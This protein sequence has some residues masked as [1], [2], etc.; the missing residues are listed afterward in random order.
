M[1]KTMSTEKPPKNFTHNAKYMHV[2]TGSVDTGSN[3]Y[4][5]SPHDFAEGLKSGAFV[6]VRAARTQKEKDVHGKWVTV[7]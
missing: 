5:E 1:A 7:E 3:W 6:K 2:W 4:T